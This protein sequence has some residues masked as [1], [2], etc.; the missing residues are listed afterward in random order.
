MLTLQIVIQFR[1]A[2]DLDGPIRRAVRARRRLRNSL[3]TEIS[4]MLRSLG[5]S[6]GEMAMYEVAI[7]EVG[8]ASAPS[9]PQPN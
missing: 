2:D 5:R 8:S 1:P 4:R 3:L 6:S 7:V 9:H